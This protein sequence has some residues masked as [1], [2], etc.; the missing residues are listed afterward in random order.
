M[1]SESNLSNI[2]LPMPT[3]PDD[4]I[5]LAQKTERDVLGLLMLWGDVNA[6][7][8]IEPGWFSSSQHLNIYFAIAA[9]ADHHSVISPA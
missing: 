2:L 6:V 4:Y 9:T 3:L 1:S 5:A 7:S 8:E